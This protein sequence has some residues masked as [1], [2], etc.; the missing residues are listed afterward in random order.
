MKIAAAMYRA[1]VKTAEIKQ[2]IAPIPLLFINAPPK[3][4]I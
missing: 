2:N 4:P 3:I 1:L